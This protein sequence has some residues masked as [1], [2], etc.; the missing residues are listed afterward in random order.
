ML[1]NRIATHLFSKNLIRFGR[2]IV[3]MP[4]SV[5]RCFSNDAMQRITDAI[6]KNEMLHSGEICFAVEANLTVRELLAK[7]T[8]VARAVEVFS[9]L[10]VWDTEQNNG[11]LIYL[12]IADHDFEILADRGI[13]HQVDDSVWE[14]ISTDMERL[15]KL[16]QFEAGVLYGIEKIGA[17]LAQHYPPENKYTNELP[18]APVVL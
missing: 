9:N 1:K 11:V 4:N 8:A 2:H 10:R 5:K 3:T 16:G 12:L 13:H 7:K 14:N 18:D 15:F 17:L 6:R